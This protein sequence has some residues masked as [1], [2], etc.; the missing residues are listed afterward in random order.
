MKKLLLIVILLLP[1]TVSA[2]IKSTF[3]NPLIDAA[4]QGIETL[5]S[6]QIRNG[7]NPNERGNFGVTPL[8]RASYRG[9][10][11]VMELLIN[12][13][14][15]V[16]L[17][18]DGGATALHLA[19]RQGNLEA[20]KLLLKYDAVVDMADSE[21]WTPLMRAVAGKKREVAELLLKAGADSEAKNEWGESAH[22][23][24]EKIPYNQP[25][26][27]SM[28]APAPKVVVVETPKV[29]AAEVAQKSISTPV[30]QVL[31]HDLP[32]Q[33]ST[34]APEQNI[35]I[36]APK[37][38]SPAP[39]VEDTSEQQSLIQRL[40]AEKAAH[41]QA[42]TQLQQAVA[43]RQ[44][45]EA[46]KQAQAEQAKKAIEEQRAEEEQ[47]ALQQKAEMEARMKAEK[48]A[49]AENERK[50]KQVAEENAKHEAEIAEKTKLD[51]QR[52]LAEAEERK[53]AKIA[54][55]NARRIAEQA[56][57]IAEKK[58]EER[59]LQLAKLEY[60]LEQEQKARRATE[61]K[62]QN[63]LAQQQKLHKAEKQV[64][65]AVTAQPASK[66]VT[67]PVA[68]NIVIGEAIAV[69]VSSD[70]LVAAAINPRPSLLGM[71]SGV[72]L[73]VGPFLE[74]RQAVV[75]Y[76]RTIEKMTDLLPPRMKVIT[77]N[78]FTQE[79]PRNFLRVGPYTSQKIA[80]MA[81]GAFRQSELFCEY[82]REEAAE[83]YSH[84]HL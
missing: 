27:A 53:Q 4:D 79:D 9:Y 18:D 17:S 81:C 64:A 13:G 36:P 49:A 22:Q 69:P 8:M 47:L 50:A 6:A 72:W 75:Y 33:Q 48:E 62:L 23:F 63:E 61:E 73:Q 26:L 44:Q 55:E 82:I 60:A 65:V 56:Q 30:E 1:F 67:S 12:L 34:A 39:A 58:E 31:P 43:T 78:L 42:E 80:K 15:D 11:N 37:T 21:G 38:A 3:G 16:N 84:G 68:E 40:E 57:R 2:Q 32:Q 76:D 59:Q 29:V 54:E 19:A 5:V 14:A 74:E 46:A 10:T 24:A 35:V 71:N 45:E 66:P 83:R 20:V 77:Q 52:Q 51:A 41:A 25:L 70:L 7:T 28:K